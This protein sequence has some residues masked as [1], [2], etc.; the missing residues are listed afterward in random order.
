MIKEFDPLAIYFGE[1]IK[2]TE[3]MTIAQA[4]LGD[5]IRVGEREYWNMINLLTSIPSDHISMLH[6][7]GINYMEISDLEFFTLMK[8]QL[9]KE[10]TEVLFGD[11]DFS[12]FVPCKRNED[13]ALVL[14]NEESK[15][16]LDEASYSLMTQYLCTTHLIKKKRRKAGN[17]K[18]Y[19]VQVEIDRQDKQLAAS[20]PN[21]SQ[22]L[23]MIS[24]LV[25]HPGFKY[26]ISQVKELTL[27]QFM[28]CVNRISV[29]T[30]V[31][32][33]AQGYYSGSI[34]PKKINIKKELDW[35]RD[36]QM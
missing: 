36:L 34:D 25:N 27:Y 12:K 14:Y 18:T 29:M 20:K 7:A 8:G 6:D 21:R 2:V 13:G 32:R 1:P 17:K 23:L 15:C 11:L 26:S 5:I 30:N 33:L 3:G 19:E 35:M 10:H 24:S 31:E 28:D 16:L 4:T 22:M 9:K